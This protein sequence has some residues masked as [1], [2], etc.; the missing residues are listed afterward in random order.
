MPGEFLLDTSIVI[1]L[2]RGED[3]VQALLSTAD[4]IFLSSIVLGELY[5]GAEKSDRVQTHRQQIQDFAES[6]TQ[7]ACDGEVARFYGRIKLQL[8]RIG[9]PIPENDLWIAATAM[10]HELALVTRDGHFSDI[11]G[12][13]LERW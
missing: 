11:E 9:K 10:R 5:F 8:A 2:F 1:P 12:L 3:T 6:C 13:A 7:L 4:E